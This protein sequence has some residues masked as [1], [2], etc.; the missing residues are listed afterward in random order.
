[1]ITE[2]I[3]YTQHQN[4]ALWYAVEDPE[5]L[6]IL[7]YGGVRGGKSFTVCKAAQLISQ[8]YPG[9]KALIGR[10]TRVNLKATTQSDF[11]DVD[12]KGNPTVMPDLYDPK[13]WNETSGILKWKNN[14]ATMFW[15]LDDR[16]SIKRI[17]STQWSFC[18]LE[19]ATGISIEI[20]KFLLRTR[21]SHPIGPRKMILTTNTDEGEEDIY[22]LFFKDHHCRR[23]EFC[24]NCQGNC[25]YRRVYSSTLDNEK[26]LPPDYVSEIKKLAASDPTY[27]AVYVLGQFK[28]LGGLIY[29][30]YDERMHVLDIPPGFEFADYEVVYGYDHGWQG[31]P[32]C[33]LEGYV[34]SDGTIIFMNEYYHIG[35]TVKEMADDW[36]ARGITRVQF[37]DP[38]VMKNTQ[39]SKNNDGSQ[40]ICSIADLFEEE[41]VYMEAADNNVD[42]GIEKV[43]NML[44]PDKDRRNPVNG[45]PNAPQWYIARVSGDMRCPNLHAQMLSYKSKPDAK[46]DFDPTGYNPIKKNDHAVDPMRYIVNGRPPKPMSEDDEPKQ[47]TAAWAR[48]K[49]MEKFVMPREPGLRPVSSAI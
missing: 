42:G 30:G 28:S 43:R 20:I 38:Q 41:G 7:L 47:G 25:R 15:G 5:A 36:K 49:A 8:K 18:A 23:G 19:E 6:A 45:I 40:K 48:Q 2:Q 12:A 32:A 21:L 4:D 26:N 17:K 11:F 3:E 1:M 16:M 39:Y 14:S 31:A 24:A 44:L 9:S 35:K 29:P 13:G 33:L 27:Y 34:L 37:C 22:K 46:G 10:D